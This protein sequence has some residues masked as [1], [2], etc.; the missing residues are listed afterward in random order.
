MK[1]IKILGLLVFFLL[2]CGINAFS[3]VTVAGSTGANGSY[4]QLNLAFTALNGAGT[5]AGNNITIDITA[6]T[7][8]TASASL[9]ASDWTSVT[10]RPSGGAR[11]IEGSIV[12][13]IIK[14]NG[15][16]N[17]TI[18]GRI[19]G[20]GTNRD[21]TVRN[22]NT[23]TATA[24]IWLA[25][26]IAGNG[27]ANNVIRNL[28]I[29]AGAT[30][31]TTTNVTHGIIQT[32]TTL[33]VG[34]A[35]GNDNDNNQ[36][37]FNRVIRARIG[38]ASRGVTTNNNL[39]AVVTDNIV[40]PGSFG[41]DEIGASGIYM[42]ADTGATVSRNTVQFV[43]G[44]L[45]NTTGGADRC[46]ICIGTNSWSATST[47]TITSGDYTVTK[48]IIHD[49]IEERTFSAV[50]IILG[51]T[52][53]GVATNNLIAN[54]FIYNLRADGTAGDQ[55]CGVCVSNGHTDRIEFNSISITGDMDPG[56]AASSTQYGNAIRISSVNGTNNANFSVRNNSIYM[57]VNANNATTHF[58][59]ITLNSAAYV[60]GTG[61]LNYNNYYVN[62]ANLQMRTGGLSAATGAAATTEFQTLANWQ[63]A[64]T[65]PQDVNSIQAD[66][67][68][69]SN[70]FDLHIAGTSPNVNTGLTIAGIADDIDGQVRPNG[71]NPDIGA[72]EFYTSPGTL[73]FSSSTYTNPETSS[74]TITVTRAAG[75]NGAVQV[76]Y[77]TV[78]GGSATGGA[79]CTAGVDY[80]NA[81]G[82]LM[83]ADLDG[84]AK[85]FSVTLCADGFYDGSETVNLALS[86][87]MVAT[88]GTPNTAVLTITDAGTVFSGSFNVG[89]AETFTS[90]TNPGGIF[91]AMNGGSLSGP[92]TINITTD[93]TGETGAIPLNETG[94]PP[95]NE[96]GGFSVLI[97]PSGAAR[98]ISTNAVTSFI[99]LAGTDNVT[100]DGSLSGG[101][102]K[103]LT[104]NGSGAGALL[105]IAT[106]ATGGANG[107]T[108]KNCILN[109]PGAF[110]GQG[111]IAGSG[112]TFGGQAEFPNSNNTIRNNTIARTQ[113]AAFIAGGTATPDVNWLII[114]NTFGSTVVADKLSFR[115]MLIRD[116]VNAQIIHNTISGVNSST[117]TSS[118]MSGIQLAGGISGGYISRNTIKDIRQ[119]NTVG[120]GS[121]GIYLTASSTASG[122]NI[123]NNMISDI[124]SQGFAG[125]TATDN[126]YGIMIDTGGGYNIYYN[127]VVMN[128]NQVAAG[129]ITA[130]LNIAAGATTVGSIDLRDNILAN[131]QT[132]G[133]RYSVYD[134]STAG[135]TI[136]SIINNNDYFS[137]QNVGFLTSAR[138]TLADWQTATGQ[139]ANSLAVDPLFVSATDF[140]IQVASPVQ[141]GGVTIASV[142]RDFDL[143][144]RAQPF[145][146]LFDDKDTPLGGGN[147]DI[148]A[149]EILA[150]TAAHAFIS[151]QVLTADGRGIRNAIVVISGGNL[152]EARTVA[153]GSFGYFAFDD[154]EVGQTYIVTVNSK[155][156]AFPTPTVVVTL[157]D[158]VGDLNFVAFP[159]GVSK[160]E[161]P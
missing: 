14:L 59:A 96:L 78:A 16:D 118:T 9:N 99:K 13:A 89:T 3:Q 117:G 113:N 8:E 150:P 128:T 2:A 37:I 35:D 160:T 107:N 69:F 86:N 98:T 53:S 108:L 132:I 32:G 77:A 159:Q 92:V 46:G 61:G 158:N 124:A 136:F 114:D 67:Q 126:G 125:V 161:E 85:N 4:A 106:N 10:I 64:L 41:A 110:A 109:G 17:V 112:T 20:V 91:Q 72:D 25:S 152:P 23:S 36:F 22:N 29:A 6:N 70:T 54:N 45:A 80:I 115:G 76:D 141:D 65:A 1:N 49:V 144:L 19:G 122:I 105:W 156:F 63:A 157:Q 81:S 143:Q 94:A 52:R 103:S 82:T 43:G 137:S 71:A 51:T 34:A 30:S 56:A 131:T 116:S 123:N 135:N 100:I 62:Q 7:T 149:D 111:I 138:V 140:H 21:L 87:V 134:A 147:T 68:Y 139:D 145:A 154:L 133:T 119:N 73:Q 12:G 39:N 38:I 79:A 58:Y 44:D 142:V 84:A 148:G 153:T 60:F 40:G 15:A 146:P 57:D 120:W 129:S 5:Q 151:G 127:T 26:V 18:D 31:N 66:P 95:L 33:S 102:D 24:A 90:L 93:L 97:K 48:N 27:A 155:R 55:V 88:L 83:W 104:I 75:I 121:N 50:G 130:A 11:I 28:E 42:Q 74:A 101:T 47:T